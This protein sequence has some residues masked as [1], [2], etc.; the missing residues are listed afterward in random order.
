MVVVTCR[1]K[2]GLA[3]GDEEKKMK[4]KR[5]NWNDTIRNCSSTNIREVVLELDPPFSL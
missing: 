4:V 2:V 1:V 3:R 5:G